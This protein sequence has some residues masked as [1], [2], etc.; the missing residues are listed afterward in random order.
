MALGVL[1]SGR[2]L[3]A[4][5]VQR[6]IRLDPATALVAVLAEAV[7]VHAFALIGVPVST[8]Q[9]LTGAL[10]GIGLLKGMQTIRL[11]GFFLI[12][13]SWIV[14]PLIAGL[15]SFSLFAL[16]RLLFP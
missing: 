12:L 16:N 14:T 5:K 4:L 1:T 8:G 9:A 13:S 11:R 2:N 7:T 6:V 10:F 3:F 15:L